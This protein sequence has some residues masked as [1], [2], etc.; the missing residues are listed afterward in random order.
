MPGLCTAD[1]NYI[2]FI[3]VRTVFEVAAAFR[4]T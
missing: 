2:Y 4:S 1:E 3:N